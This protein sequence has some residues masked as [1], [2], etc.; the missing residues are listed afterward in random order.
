[1]QGTAAD[2]IKLAMIS[3][4]DWLQNSDLRSVMIMQVHDELVLEVPEDELQ[5]VSEGLVQRMESAAALK[6]PLLVDVG[7]GDNWDEA[8]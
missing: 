8:H 5:V 1:M 7:V 2:I 3:V 4:D 6:V